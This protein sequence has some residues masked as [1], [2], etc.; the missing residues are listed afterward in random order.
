MREELIEVQNWLTQL[1]YE[2]RQKRT[3]GGLVLPP[4]IVDNLEAD[5]QILVSK[6]DKIIAEL[7]KS[8]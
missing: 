5:V 1:R 6:L 3:D 8:K 2:L 7:S 4:Q